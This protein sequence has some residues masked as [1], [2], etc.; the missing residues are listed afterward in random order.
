MSLETR[1]DPQRSVVVGYSDS[2]F[3]PVLSLCSFAFAII[4]GNVLS[5]PRHPLPS[6]SNT[7]STINYH[8]IVALH[9]QTVFGLWKEVSSDITLTIILYPL[10][11]IFSTSFAKC[12]QSTTGFLPIFRGLSFGMDHGPVSTIHQAWRRWS[13]IF[14]IVKGSN[15]NDLNPLPRRGETKESFPRRK[16]TQNSLIFLVRTACSSE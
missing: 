3:V 9:A 4:Y 8:R 11:I 6:L 15:H 10:T 1:I 13:R 7:A 5:L 16:Q 2:Y 14:L 12:D